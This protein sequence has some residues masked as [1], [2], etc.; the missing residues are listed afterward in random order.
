MRLEQSL[1]DRLGYRLEPD[2][3]PRNVNYYLERTSHG[4]TLSGVVNAWVLARSDRTRSWRFFAEALASD[5]HDVQGGTTAEGIHLGAMAGTVDGS[6]AQAKDQRTDQGTL[7]VEGMMAA[8]RERQEGE[9]HDHECEH[10]DRDADGVEAV[11]GPV[12]GEH[13]D[14]KGCEGSRLVAVPANGMAAFASYKPDPAGGHAPWSIQLI[15]VSG[16]RI[17]GHHN[18][19]DTSL[20]AYF[21]L[22]DHL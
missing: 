15:E 12:E 14:G 2:A 17:V 3:I 21:G 18:F 1:L 22:P 7:P 13:G 9:R 19:L 8:W 10:P 20:F 16:D 5:L 4:S 11:G 6:N